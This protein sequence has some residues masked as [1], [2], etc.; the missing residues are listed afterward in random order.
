MAARDPND[1]ASTMLANL[2]EVLGAGIARSALPRGHAVAMRAARAGLG[3]LDLAVLGRRRGL[4]R[5]DQPPRRAGDL[6]DGAIERIVVRAARLPRAAD[7]AH[8]L[9]RRGVDLL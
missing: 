2:V 5:V 3:G 4:E 1:D 7:L 8:V 9:Q 6:D